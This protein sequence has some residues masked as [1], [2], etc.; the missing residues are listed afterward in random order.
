MASVNCS[1]L[2]DTLKSRMRMSRAELRYASA[3]YARD[4]ATLTAWRSGLR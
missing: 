4:A 2:Y 1:R 3:S